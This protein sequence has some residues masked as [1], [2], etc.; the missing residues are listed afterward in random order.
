MEKVENRKILMLVNTYF[1]IIVA[2]KLKLTLY[3]NDDV[4]IIISDHSTDAYKIFENVRN[5]N[6]FNKV[7]FFRSKNSERTR[8]KK[9]EENI[10]LLFFQNDILKKM[11]LDLDVY[12]E[13]LFYNINKYSDLIYSALLKKNK[14]LKL[15]RFEEGYIS[16]LHP[17][18]GLSKSYMKLKKIFKRKQLQ[19]NIDVNYFFNPNI[20]IY[21]PKNSIVKIDKINKIDEKFKTIMN[22]VFEYNCDNN[23][24]KQRYI[25]FEE[26]FFCDGK[27]ID[28]LDLILKIADIVGKENILVKLHPRNKIDRFSKYGIKTNKSVGIPWEIIQ[29]NNDFSDKVFLTISSGSVLGSRL[30]FDDNIKTYLL[31]NCTNKKSD[32]VTENYLN[33]LDKVKNEFGMDKFIIPKNKDEFYDILRKERDGK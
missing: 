5:M 2:I 4:D 22:D 29:M 26:S 24:Y 27:E 8:I 6:L 31:F 13:F 12:D 25:F 21:E 9:I 28:D 20:L 18:I 3:K 11:K 14:N 30:Y 32:M 17:N 19:E 1:Q 23:E 10:M 15:G 16:Y 33:Y 7:I